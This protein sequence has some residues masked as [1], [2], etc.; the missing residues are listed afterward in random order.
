MQKESVLHSG[1]AEIQK[2]HSNKHM[3]S[4]S[5]IQKKNRRLCHDSSR[6]VECDFSV[7]GEK[8]KSNRVSYFSVGLCQPL[9]SE[10]KKLD[11]L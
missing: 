2:T 4:T 8:T 1:P 6:R 5:C 3:A 10:I 9:P 11:K 7:F